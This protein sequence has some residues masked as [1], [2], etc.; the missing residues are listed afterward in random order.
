MSRNFEKYDREVVRVVDFFVRVIDDSCELR[1]LF[2]GERGG[3]GSR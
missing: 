3:L 2:E 1:S